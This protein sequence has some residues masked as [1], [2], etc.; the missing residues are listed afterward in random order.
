M[1]PNATGQ[2]PKSKLTKK[3]PSPKSPILKIGLGLNWGLNRLR[4]ELSPIFQVGLRPAMG[5]WANFTLLLPIEKFK[6]S[7]ISNQYSMKLP[8]A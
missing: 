6:N 5:R 8:H 2:N 1:K 7:Y 3:I 4:V